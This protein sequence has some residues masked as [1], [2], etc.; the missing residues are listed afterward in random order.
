MFEQEM[1]TYEKHQEMLER[2]H[3]MQYVVI[4]GDKI[5]GTF[6]DFSAD[7]DEFYVDGSMVKQVGL[8]YLVANYR[9]IPSHSA[10]S[11]GGVEISI[12]EALREQRAA[13]ARRALHEDSRRLRHLSEY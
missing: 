6:D 13:A 10:W 11:K 8:A 12:E 4:K 5:L 3:Y 7:I 2:D 1:E 9:G